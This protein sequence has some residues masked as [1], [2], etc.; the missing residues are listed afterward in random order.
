M[1]PINWLIVV[2]YVTYVLVDGVRRA[3]GTTEVEGYFLAN[4]SL[5][6]WAV[7]LSVMATQLSA[8]TMIGTTGQGATDGLRFVQFYFGLPLAMVLLGVTLV[9]FLR[10]AGVFTA[11]E[12]LERRFGPR[13]RA[14]TAFLFLLSRGMSC[15]VIIAAP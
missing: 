14:L 13:T 1:H 5:P 4:R 9:P 8:V 15:G 6:W 3:R 10:G 7:G 11:Y 2:A 12:Y